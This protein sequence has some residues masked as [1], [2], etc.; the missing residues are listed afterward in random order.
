[1]KNYR[2]LK[3]FPIIKKNLGLD[4]YKGHGAVLII[5]DILNKEGAIIGL[6]INIKIPISQVSNYLEQWAAWKN[7][8]KYRKR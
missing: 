8:Y 1:M 5:S 6:N 7:A 2:L 4:G 3:L